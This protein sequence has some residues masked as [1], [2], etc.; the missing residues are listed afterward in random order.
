M[1]FINNSIVCFSA[2]R[3]AFINGKENIERRSLE[4]SYIVKTFWERATLTP[5]RIRITSIIISTILCMFVVLF[6]FIDD[7]SFWN[8]LTIIQSMP[9]FMFAISGFIL[10]FRSNI[11]E[12]VSKKADLSTRSIVN[13]NKFL[14]EII[15]TS[16]MLAII[17]MLLMPFLSSGIA[18]LLMGIAWLYVIFVIFC[19]SIN[20]YYICNEA[21][22]DC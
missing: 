19:I 22:K 4:M 16:C 12:G 8:Y 21:H 18:V 7:G 3:K 6:K 1:P 14:Q 13:F 5:K 17:S 2:G 11:L 15:L 9:L 10:G 20:S